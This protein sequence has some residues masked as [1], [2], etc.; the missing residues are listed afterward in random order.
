MGRNQGRS[1]DN[2][3]TIKRRFETYRNETVPIGKHFEEKGMFKKI[4]GK[5]EAY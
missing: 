2:E 4:D 5:M 3:A 1:D